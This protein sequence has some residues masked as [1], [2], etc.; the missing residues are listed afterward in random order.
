MGCYKCHQKILAQF[1]LDALAEKLNRKERLRLTGGRRVN[2]GTAFEKGVGWAWLMDQGV[3]MPQKESMQ[4]LNQAKLPD[5]NGMDAVA[6]ALRAQGMGIKFVSRRLGVSHFKYRH[7]LKRNGLPT[8]VS[9]SDSMVKRQNDANKIARNRECELRREE[10]K[11]RA[12][13]NFI[14]PKIA[15]YW[16][17]VEKS[18]EQGRRKARDTYHR[19]K[20][21]PLYRLQR[22]VR[23]RV[24]IC[25]RRTLAKKFA[26]THELIGCDI[27]TLMDHLEL[28]FCDG[29]SWA[30]YGPAWHVDHIIPVAAFDLHDPQQQRAAFHYTNLQPLW[31]VDNWRKNSR[32]H[33]QSKAIRRK[34][35]VYNQ[36]QISDTTPPPQGV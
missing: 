3:R 31:A 18:R 35:H 2:I 34:T 10:R 22:H 8:E 26:R 27:A 6:L 1:S 16:R 20:A 32:L 4:H 9:Y 17:N 23:T 15:K 14:G 5:L 33:P 24:S 21:D 13:A 19:R 29:M 28:R 12:A 11:Q 25:I 36:M 7:W 30:N